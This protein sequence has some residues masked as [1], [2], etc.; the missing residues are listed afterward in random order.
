MRSRLSRGFSTW[1]IVSGSALSRTRRSIPSITATMPTSPASPGSSGGNLAEDGTAGD[2]RALVCQMAWHLL[3]S[4]RS[5]AH[6]SLD[7]ADRVLHMSLEA[8]L[9]KGH[10]G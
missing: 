2:A 3:G 1:R 8:A 10:T 4:I 7:N 6:G 5:G 9:T